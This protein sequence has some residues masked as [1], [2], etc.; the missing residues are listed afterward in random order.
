MT[1]I[2][3]LVVNTNYKRLLRNPDDAKGGMLRV[4]SI[5]ASSQLPGTSPPLVIGLC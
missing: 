2:W 4:W 1:Y 5:L 3:Y